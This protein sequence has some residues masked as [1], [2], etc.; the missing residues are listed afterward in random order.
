MLIFETCL[1][2][3]K[4]IENYLGNS[5]FFQDDSAKTKITPQIF[6]LLE[7]KSWYIK[8]AKQIKKKKLGQTHILSKTFFDAYWALMTPRLIK[9]KI[10]FYHKNMHEV[11]NLWT[12]S[13]IHILIKSVFHSNYNKIRKMPKFENVAALLRLTCDNSLNRS[14]AQANYKCNK[15]VSW[16]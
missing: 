9:A 10:F 16:A 11:L 12:I 3:W 15:N 5:A 7:K 13:N 8:G 6:D 14:N 1:R 2:V 4:C